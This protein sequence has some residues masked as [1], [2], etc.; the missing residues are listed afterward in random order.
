MAKRYRDNQIWEEDWFIILPP[1]YKLLWEW[2]N[3]KCDHAGIWKPNLATFEKF[4]GEVDL[5]KALD[6]FNDE[7]KTRVIKLKNG[8]FFITG[9]FVFQYG[10][11][12]NLNNKVHFSINEIYKLQGV[13]IDLVRGLKALKDMDKDKEKDIDSISKKEVKPKNEKVEF[14]PFVTMTNEE[15]SKLIEEHGLELTKK[16]IEK[17]DNYKGSSGKKY[18]DD[19]RAI[20]SWVIQDVNKKN[21][22]KG[23]VA[24]PGKAQFLM[25]QDERLKQLDNE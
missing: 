5:I 17:L 12:L 11:D 16:F 20:L 21:S 6:F 10:E 3:D 14:A 19:Y 15:H 25:A 9:F 2:M 22:V 18:K 24:T 23:S 8:K 7:E 13:S 1:V 4:N